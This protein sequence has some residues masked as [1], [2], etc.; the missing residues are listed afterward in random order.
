[1]VTLTPLQKEDKKLWDT[2]GEG[3][4]H[5]KDRPVS[6][7]QHEVMYVQKLHYCSSCQ[8]IRGC[9]VTASWAARHTNMCL[10]IYVIYHEPQ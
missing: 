3:H 1:M 6:C 10:D 8:Y 7:K 5:S 2:D 9:G 4:H